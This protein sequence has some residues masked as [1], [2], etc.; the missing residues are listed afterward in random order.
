MRSL[1]DL[2]N[3]GNNIKKRTVKKDGGGGKWRALLKTVIRLPVPQNREIS[4]R[5]EKLLTSH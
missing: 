2:G 3:E 4:S 5:S 1:E